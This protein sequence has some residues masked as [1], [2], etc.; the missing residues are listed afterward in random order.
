MNKMV[1][2]KALLLGFSQVAQANDVRDYLI[3]GNQLTS[4]HV[5]IFSS[6][7]HE[8]NL[9][10]PPLWDSEVTNVTTAPF[11]DKLM[12]FHAGVLTQTAVA[13][14][15]AALAVSMRRDLATQYTRLTA[16]MEQ[17]G[18]DGANILINHGWLEQPPTADD[19]AALVNES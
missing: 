7:L 3:R 12:M 2:Q 13:F 8:D 4:K 17:Y 19:R 6:L 15:G 16:E 14:Y 9:P 1:M 10:S 5:E 11:S 18:E